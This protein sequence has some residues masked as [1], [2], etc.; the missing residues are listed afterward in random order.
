[1]EHTNSDKSG[2]YKKPRKPK[3]NNS[4]IDNL[5]I[6]H[7]KDTQQINNNIKKVKANENIVMVIDRLNIY[8][9]FVLSLLYYLNKYYITDGSFTKG[10]ERKFHLWCYNKVC[11]DFL[12][13]GLDFKDNSF[14]E[15]YFFDELYR[16]IESQVTFWKNF[17]NMNL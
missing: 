16:D 13:E 8:K 12:K 6:K 17:F 7:D 4:F 14:L 10:D 2:N 1:M 9:D 5:F 15:E 3:K 11:D